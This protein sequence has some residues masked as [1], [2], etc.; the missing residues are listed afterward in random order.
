MV[1]G[2]IT[3]AVLFIGVLLVL[4]LAHEWGHFFMARR[5]GVKVLEFGFG[6]PPKLYG[7]FRHGTEYRLNLIPLG[8]FVR[9]K[10]EDG[11]DAHDSDSFAH[12]K[13]WQRLT[14]LLAGVFMNFFLGYVLFVVAFSLGGTMT[15]PQEDAHAIVS[16]A[17][18]VAAGVLA[19]S[20][21]ARAGILPGDEL[22]ALGLATQGGRPADS[23]GGILASD[24]Q[25]IKEY[26]TAHRDLD[27]I[28][29]ARRAGAG[30]DTMTFRAHPVE[31]M[32]GVIGIGVQMTEIGEVHYAFPYVFVRAARE[33]R[34][35]SLLIFKSLGTVVAKLVHHG[36]LEEGVSGPVGI[37][38][39]TKQVAHAGLV[40]FLELVAML[41]VNLGLLNAL[42]FPALDGGRALFVVLEKVLR[43]KMRMEIERATHLMGF[44]LLMLLV[45]AVT[46]RDI[47]ALL[48]K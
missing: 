36:Q 11:S 24:P 13:A 12:K 26:I 28:L 9:L 20:P 5:F 34:E 40:P 25:A 42:P 44:A 23:G 41:S 8:G 30:T 6:F 1:Y 15:L 33:T 16:H 27:I 10:G 29:I 4:V 45:I 38:V 7:W 35:V 18:V 43:K 22:V 14:I 47:I 19:N 21:A 2:F 48:H 31:L 46:Y 3:T 39:V 32:P 37:A 17:R